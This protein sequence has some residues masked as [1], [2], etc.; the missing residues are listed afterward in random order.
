MCDQQTT[1]SATG[2]A[3]AWYV[4]NPGKVYGYDPTD[5]GPEVEVIRGI[6][7]VELEEIAD[8]YPAGS[9]TGDMARIAL[10]GMY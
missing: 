9:L 4:A 1:F 2:H 7:R 5:D 6:S 10:K 3:V 8:K